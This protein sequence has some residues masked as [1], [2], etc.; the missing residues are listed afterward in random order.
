MLQASGRREPSGIIY[1]ETPREG[2]PGRTIV[3]IILQDALVMDTLGSIRPEMKRVSQESFRTE[4]LER[5]RYLAC[6]RRCG[7]L[8][9]RR[10]TGKTELLET[11]SSELEREGISTSRICL[12]GLAPED[13]VF[14]IACDLG[15]GVEPGHS[16]RMI[17][18]A[19]QEYAQASQ[20]SGN[21]H[22]FVFDQV[23]RADSSMALQFERLLTLF[24]DTFAVIFVSRPQ[25]QPEFKRLLKN[26]SWMKVRIQRLSVADSTQVLAKELSA[27]ERDLQI[28]KEAAELA[29]ELT[30]GRLDRLKRLSELAALAAEAEELKTVNAEILRSLQLEVT[31]D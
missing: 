27:P 15:L 14:Q 11:L 9:G 31:L 22:V 8:V 13:V 1:E 17:W 4:A 2:T 7:I 24:D 10:G 19:L 28:T 12:A 30:K 29:V 26:H 25:I 18:T 3:R 20:M 21:Q 6:H 5:L 16:L 23:D